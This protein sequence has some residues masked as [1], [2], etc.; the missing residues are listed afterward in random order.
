M[1]RLRP[2]TEAVA[3]LGVG[4][5]FGST[6]LGNV[7]AES[8]KDRRPDALSFELELKGKG[9]PVRACLIVTR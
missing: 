8:V 2:P 6:F 9:S 1:R 5:H 7:G 3:A 4:V